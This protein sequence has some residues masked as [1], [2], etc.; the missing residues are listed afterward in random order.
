MDRYLIA[1]AWAVAILFGIATLM[2]LGVSTHQT[3]FF[4]IPTGV[5]IAALIVLPFRRRR[6]DAALP[7]ELSRVAYKVTESSIA[8][9]WKWRG[10]P[11]RMRILKSELRAAANADEH[12][13]APDQ[14]LIYDGCEDGWVDAGVRARTE[15]RYTL[16]AADRDGA[17]REPIRLRLAALPLSD[18]VYQETNERLGTYREKGSG[19]VAAPRDGE[20]RD[21]LGMQIVSDPIG[22]PHGVDVQ[23]AQMLG[24]AAPLAIA[25]DVL[26]GIVTDAI[27]ATADLLKGQPKDNGWREV[28]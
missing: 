20:R 14:H 17:W 3:L 16:F 8:F 21:A 22:D 10:A 11:T 7:R 19:A 12:L 28:E 18:Q 2:T 23:R 24:E 4:A 5:A 25:G 6:I 13:T 9:A 27:F 1:L 15:Y 26:G